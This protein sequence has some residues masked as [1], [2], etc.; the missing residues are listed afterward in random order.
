M[1]NWNKRNGQRATIKRPGTK[2]Y[3]ADYDNKTISS[4]INELS[5]GA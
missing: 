1:Q 5:L 3:N 2:Q 4:L